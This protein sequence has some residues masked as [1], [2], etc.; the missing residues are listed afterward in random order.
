MREQ[1]VR[2][3]GTEQVP[4]L[5]VGNKCDLQHQRQVR[6]DEGIAL[7]FLALHKGVNKLL[8][9]A[10]ASPPTVFSAEY[11]SCP[12]TE[13]S[14][15]NNH[16]VNVTFAEIVREMNYVQNKARENKGCCSIM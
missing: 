2:V 6:T 8:T 9:T 10:A 4:I 16:N 14:A 7:G 11:W 1:I 3:K 15:K 13:C 12:F 5:L